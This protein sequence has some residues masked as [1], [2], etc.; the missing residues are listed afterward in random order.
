[1][2]VNYRA[3]RCVAAAVSP[4]MPAT[5]LICLVHIELPDGGITALAINEDTITEHA[6][7]DIVKEE[8]YIQSEVKRV[9]TSMMAGAVGD[10]GI[11]KIN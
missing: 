6:H 3:A 11:A 7:G 8:L 10:L 9:I 2:N 4:G 1:M 5:T